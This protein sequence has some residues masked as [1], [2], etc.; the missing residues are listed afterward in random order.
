M[1]IGVNV[2]APSGGFPKE[3]ENIAGCVFDK[4][5]KRYEKNRLTAKILDNFFMSITKIS[6][7][8]GFV[9]CYKEKNSLPSVKI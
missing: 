8:R 3:I 9:E 7:N 2:Y 1:G 6:K 5:K 4:Q